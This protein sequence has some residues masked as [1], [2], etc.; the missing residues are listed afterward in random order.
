MC[1]WVGGWL[2]GCGVFAIVNH[3]TAIYNNN[4]ALKYKLYTICRYKRRTHPK[5]VF[6]NNVSL[7][8]IDQRNVS[9]IRVPEHIDIYSGD[10]DPF[11]F[12]AQ[13]RLATEVI[14]MPT[15]SFHRI[16]SLIQLP[17]CPIVNI[18][19][20]GRC[21]STLMSQFFEAIPGVRSY[22][23]CGAFKNLSDFYVRQSMGDTKVLQ[24]LRSSV[25]AFCK[26]GRLPLTAVVFKQD[27]Q[28]NFL[29]SM[30]NELFPQM[31]HLF[32]YRDIIP[33]II[34]S[35]I[36]RLKI[37]ALGC[38]SPILS[39]KSLMGR[40]DNVQHLYNDKILNS[41]SNLEYQAKIWI[42][43]IE[44][45]LELRAR[46]LNIKSVRYEDIV[47][48]HCRQHI[49]HKGAITLVLAKNS[50]QSFNHIFNYY[51]RLFETLEKIFPFLST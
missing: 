4:Y 19:N 1:A 24:L 23:E 46:N 12:I 38:S 35:E 2:G 25:K 48:K 30:L 28:S 42:R 7:Y 40:L 34:S 8:S 13:F 20:T 41:L 49:L 36:S 22:S 5:V 15:W 50:V 18:P 44:H 6:D 51:W 21:G 14:S 32:M 16:A 29:S 39:W 31:K 27:S 10:T 43:Y 37:I 45:Y 11:F 17:Q 26:P 9:F 33:F 47:D 3:G